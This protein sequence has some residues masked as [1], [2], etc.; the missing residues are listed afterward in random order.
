MYDQTN[1][2]NSIYSVVT[3]MGT[4]NSCHCTPHDFY[5][6]SNNPAREKSEIKAS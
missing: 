5:T 3:R 6:F 2:S 4:T 1:R